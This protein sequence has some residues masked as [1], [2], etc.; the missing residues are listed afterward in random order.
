MGYPEWGVGWFPQKRGGS[1]PG[2]NYVERTLL[3]LT[4]LTQNLWDDLLL[5]FYSKMW[6]NWFHH[7]TRVSFSSWQWMDLR[8]IGTFWNCLVTNWY[9][10]TWAKQWTLEVVHSMSFMG[11]WK[12]ERS[13]HNS[14]LTKSWNQCCGSLKLC[15]LGT[16]STWRKAFVESFLSGNNSIYTSQ[17]W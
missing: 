9:L 16:M 7:W 4:T 13:L 12:L 1:N 10:K 5:M 6:M 3:K 17:S 11:L 2:G 15:L 8:L 14:T